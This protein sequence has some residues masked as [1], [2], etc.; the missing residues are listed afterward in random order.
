MNAIYSGLS[1][2]HGRFNCENFI[3]ALLLSSIVLKKIP[4]SHLWNNLPQIPGRMTFVCSS[5]TV[6]IDFAHTPDALTKLLNEMRKLADSNSLWIVFGAGGDRDK[7]KRPLMT[8]A[9]IQYADK[10]ILTS[11]NPRT[12]D[13]DSIIDDLCRG[14]E[15]EKKIRRI[16]NRKKAIEYTL[17]AAKKNDFIIVAGKGHEQYQQI[18]LE[19]KPFCDH[20]IIKKFLLTLQA[21]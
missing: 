6:V 7:S 14:Y 1:P 18:G 12:E 21:K 20:N 11:D 17:T 3:A 15:H 9:A 16:L 4:Q 10:I 8:K 2:Y 5:P 19:K 13:P